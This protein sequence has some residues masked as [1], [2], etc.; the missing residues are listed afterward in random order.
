[1]PLDGQVASAIWKWSSKWKYVLYFLFLKKRRFWPSPLSTLSF[2]GFGYIQSADI[3]R[4]SGKAVVRPLSMLPWANIWH[5]DHVMKGF[6]DQWNLQGGGA[7]DRDRTGF[8]VYCC[9]LEKGLHACI[10]IHLHSLLFPFP[11]SQGQIC[12]LALALPSPSPDS[13]CCVPVTIWEPCL[14]PPVLA[15]L[16]PFL[17]SS[18]T[19]WMTA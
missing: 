13:Q 14:S 6:C 16:P 18:L 7:G 1:M 12:P 15:P 10:H 11:P 5:G 8:H 4:G 2:A 17:R 9:S 3:V 19:L